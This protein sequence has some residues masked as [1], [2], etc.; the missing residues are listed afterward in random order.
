MRKYRESSLNRL[1]KERIKYYV[2]FLL[3][4]SQILYNIIG[5]LLREENHI[6]GIAKAINENHMT[7]ARKITELEERNIIDSK[8]EGR[9]KVCF[10]KDSLEAAAFTKQFE[11][12][13]LIETIKQYPRLRGIVEHLQEREDI[14]LAIIFGSYAKGTATKKSDI[15][16][17]IETTRRELGL[18]IE[19]WD[20]KLSVKTGKFD[21]E[22]PV[23]REIIK[24][25]VIVKGVDRYHAL[26]Y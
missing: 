22:N 5:E 3:H 26:V 9:N 4:M 20:S 11:H 2:T 24:N 25:H 19:L 14:P 13:K 8:E 1:E 16:L 7:V 12:H 18:E 6:R 10:V 17:Y 21:K 15:D 23:I